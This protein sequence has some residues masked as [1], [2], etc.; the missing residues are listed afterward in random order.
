MILVVDIGNFKSAFGVFTHSPSPDTMLSQPHTR[1]TGADLADCCA[2]LGIR[3]QDVEGCVLASVAPDLTGVFRASAERLFPE[4]LVLDH[5]TPTG[6]PIHYS[7]PSSLGADRIADALALLDLYGGPACSVDIGTAINID[8]VSANGEYLGGAIAP[9]PGTAA[10]ALFAHAARL[11]SLDWRKPEKALGQ[12]T[13]GCLR[14]GCILGYGGL[15][16]HLVKLLEAEAGPFKAVVATGGAAELLAPACPSIREVR[17]A[18]TLE[19]LFAA[20]RRTRPAAR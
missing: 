10:D 17:P 19:G 2:R 18:L 16:E 3:P 9:G 11:Q 13:D 1:E 14:S 15:V 5:T 8:V 12:S 6:M 4:T 20:W 7:P